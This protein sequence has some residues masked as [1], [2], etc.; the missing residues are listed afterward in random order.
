M[1][2]QVSL[3]VSVSNKAPIT[4]LI[5]PNEVFA[6]C[7]QTATLK[8]IVISGRPEGHTFIWELV[9]GAQVIFTSDIHK[10]TTTCDL[11]DIS[12]DRIFKCTVDKGRKTEKP[13]YLTFWGTATETSPTVISNTTLI[14][15]LNIL[16]SSPTCLSI[17]ETQAIFNSNPTGLCS[18]NP[19]NKILVWDLPTN[20][21]GLRSII[22]EQIINGVWTDVLI[23]SPTDPQVLHNATN[24]TYYRIKTI[25]MI[26]HLLYSQYSCVYY[27]SIDEAN[28][29]GYIDEVLIPMSN[30]LA[31]PQVT[32]YV[33]SNT[34]ILDTLGLTISNSTTP[35]ALT[36]YTLTSNIIDDNATL[37]I[38]NSSLSP[39]NVTYY[40]GVVI[41]G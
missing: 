24:K 6:P 17:R 39:Y 1:P 18:I 9:S 21:N 32:N 36:V 33:L 11:I 20:L 23:L 2:F 41:G 15:G 28:Y 8:A 38:S 16:N 35:S 30:S 10:L 12:S 5:D 29:N 25:Y 14:S 31:P 26:E 37:N 3:C 40:G 34:D 13:Y 7:L 4:L 19:N 27:A 22:V